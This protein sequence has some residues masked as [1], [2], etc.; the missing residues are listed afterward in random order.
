MIVAIESETEITTPCA[1]YH[2]SLD[3]SITYTLYP[4]GRQA[5]PVLIHSSS[6]LLY[7]ATW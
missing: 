2:H 5:T 3:A 6:T 1:E 7:I 4:T